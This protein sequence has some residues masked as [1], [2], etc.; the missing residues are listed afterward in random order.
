M[1]SIP[2]ALTIAGSGSGGGAGIQAGLKSFSA[3]RVYGASVLTALTAQNTRGV[4][5][6]Y[7]VPPQF[8]KDQM[9]A[10]F[11]DNF[12][13]GEIKRFTKKVDATG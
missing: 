3:N 10:V 9:D 7:D 12:L 6:I 5:A 2:I 13:A 4:T 11:S 8:I 1:S